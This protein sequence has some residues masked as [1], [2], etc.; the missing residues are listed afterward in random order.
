MTTTKYVVRC[1]DDYESRRF[2][3]KT[4]ACKH[5]ER[6]AQLGA[7]NHDHAVVEVFKL[8]MGRW[9]DVV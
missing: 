5:L 4:D 1:A 6:I 2:A 8:D 3:T 9:V 7:C